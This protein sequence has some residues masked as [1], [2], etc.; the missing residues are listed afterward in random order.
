MF[1][2]TISRGTAAILRAPTLVLLQKAREHPWPACL[3]GLNFVC[4]VHG[5]GISWL[6]ADACS[7]VAW[8][9]G[10]CEGPAGG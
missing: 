3:S 10:S 9:A 4:P 7:T 2:G 5:M 8:R 6:A 1:A